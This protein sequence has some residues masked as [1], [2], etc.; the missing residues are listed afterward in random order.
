MLC[1][2]AS[3]RAA[4]PTPAL[5]RQTLVVPGALTGER[6][7]PHGR[8]SRAPPRC[9]SRSHDGSAPFP[10]RHLTARCR[11]R[12]REKQVALERRAYKPPAHLA[13]LPGPKPRDVAQ[14]DATRAH[15]RKT[16]DH[17]A[18]KPAAPLPTAA[19]PTAMLLRR[20]AAHASCRLRL[21]VLLPCCPLTPRQPHRAVP[22]ARRRSQIAAKARAKA[23]KESEEV[24][25]QAEILQLVSTQLREGR[26][27]DLARKAEEQAVLREA[28]DR[29]KALKELEK[30]VVTS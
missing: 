4:L 28:W 8:R 6:P 11:L 3:R 12:R 20:S 16:L 18:S 2:A 5:Q 27:R 25:A 15:L 13:V 9:H 30:V 19:L 17:Q 23:A 1:C 7:A 10:T 26:Q 29:Q 14:E 21:S 22:S 24:A